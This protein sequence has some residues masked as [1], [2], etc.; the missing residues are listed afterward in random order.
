M[1]LKT[2]FAQVPTPK[3]C[4][5]HKLKHKS[6]KTPSECGDTKDKTDIVNTGIGVAE[7]VKGTLQNVDKSFNNI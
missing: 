5:G 1:P 3:L 4:D 2:F 6:K 7:E